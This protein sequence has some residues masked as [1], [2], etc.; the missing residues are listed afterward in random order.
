MKKDNDK[1]PGQ[2]FNKAGKGNYMNTDAPEKLIKYVTRTNGRPEDDLIAW[3]ALELLN[4]M[5]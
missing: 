5:I 4:I 2:L 3:A 1:K